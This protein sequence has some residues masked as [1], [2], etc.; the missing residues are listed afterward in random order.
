[1]VCPTKKPESFMAQYEE[2]TIDKGSDVS[3]ELHLE[4]A[5]GNTKNLS[6]HSITGTM[7]KSYAST[8]AFNF[9][10]VIANPATDGIATL[11]LTN[12]QTALLDTGRY[13]YDVNISFFDSDNNEIIERIIEGRI[14]VTPNV[15]EVSGST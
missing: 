7:K 4:D 13:V 3:I 8:A 5:N 11:S 2:F 9:T 15:T 10:T 6:N 12:A 1:M 14:Q